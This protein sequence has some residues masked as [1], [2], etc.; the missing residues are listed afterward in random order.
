MASIRYTIERDQLVV[1]KVL[2]LQAAIERAEELLKALP[3]GEAATF[4]VLQSGAHLVAFITNRRIEGLFTKQVWGGRKNDLAIFEGDE[5]FDGT[6]AILLL[7]RDEILSLEDHELSTDEIGVQHIQW[8]G[9]FE[10]SITS[11]ICDFFGVEDLED[12]TEEAVDFA[13]QRYTPTVPVV[14]KVKLMIEVSVRKIGG[15]TVNEFIE[16]LDYSVVSN[17]PGIVVLETEIVDAD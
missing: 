4:A 16:N 6:D 7:D 3:E 9:P 11:S 5:K 15:A 14:E 13:K 12:I 10:V 1:D 2:G 8:D 17:T